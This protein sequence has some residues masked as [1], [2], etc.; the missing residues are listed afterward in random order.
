[1]KHTQLGEFEELVLLIVGSLHDNAYSISIKNELKEKT[2]RNPSIGALHSALNRLEK[3]GFINSFEGGATA[4][5][6]GRRK[7][8]YEIT[9]FGRNALDQSFELRSS[10]YHTLPQVSYARD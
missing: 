5:R 4:E 6:G 10:L 3:K 1:M 9:A 7:R 8:F 2:K